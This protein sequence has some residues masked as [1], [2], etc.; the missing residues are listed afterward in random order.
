MNNQELKNTY[1]SMHLEGSSAWFSNG[2][3]E[4]ELILKMGEPWKYK[5]CLEIG[6]GEGDL[7][8][9]ILDR[10]GSDYVGIDYSEIAINKALTKYGTAHD[11]I[12]MD[13]HDLKSKFDRIVMQG[14][15]EHLDDPFTEL[16]WMM[17]N[18]LT[19]KGDVITSSPC[20]LNPRGIV[21]MTL[22]IMFGA[23]MSKT[24][25]HFLNPSDFSTFCQNN[26]YRYF[27][28]TCDFDW[29]NG[30]RMIQDLTKRIPLALRDGKIP[31]SQDKVDHF[32]RWLEEDHFCTNYGATAVYKITK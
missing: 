21:W 6:C 19:E 7:G 25:L 30:E 28:D 2:E 17:D 10:S 18:L 23:V 29:S 15:L 11:F 8:M 32:I 3:E 13:Y 22:G 27:W 14:V 9:E 16:K 26:N 4:R 5:H 31:F 1:N 20:F 12:A 24:D